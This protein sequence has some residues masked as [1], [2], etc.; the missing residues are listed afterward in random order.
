MD[1]FEQNINEIA[2]YFPDQLTNIA[3]QARG[4]CAALAWFERRHPEHGGVTTAGAA[5]REGEPG[6]TRQEEQ[7]TE[8][9]ASE[10]RKEP[11]DV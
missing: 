4:M 6:P 11:E 10:A 1:I 2:A 5:A 7:S 9:I 3:D 8:S